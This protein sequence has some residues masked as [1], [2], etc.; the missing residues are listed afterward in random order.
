MITLQEFVHF[1]KLMDMAKS[2]EEVSMVTSE[3]M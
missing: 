3:S 1:M 2:K